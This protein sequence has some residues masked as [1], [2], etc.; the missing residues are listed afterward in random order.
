MTK[1]IVELP[2]VRDPERVL[3]I[4]RSTAML[5]F[6][7]PQRYTLPETAGDDY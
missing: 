3:K 6:R 1:I 7:L 4:V 5:E 2:G